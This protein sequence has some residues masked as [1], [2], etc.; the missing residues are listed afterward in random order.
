[1]SIVDNVTPAQQSRALW[2]STIA[3]TT[4]FAVW[5]IF[6]IIGLQIQ[7]DL[8]LSETEFGLLVG[9]PIL[10]GS[11]IR[12]ILG[13]WSDQ[14]GGRI[15][16]TIV[17]ITAAIATFLLT[18]VDTYFMYLVAAL[19]IGIA[20]GSFAVGIA[21][22][23]RW[24]P[25]EKQGTALGIFGLGNVGAAVT[26][27][28]APFV[29]VAFGWHAVAQI[30]GAALL[31]M[32]A[33]FWFVSED[34]PMLKARRVSGA[35]PD[36]FIKQLEPLKNIQVWRFSLYYFC[37]FGAFVALALWLPRYLVGAYGF[38]IKVAGMLAA[39]YSIFASLFRALG[40]WLSDRFGAR[41][42]M[43]WTFIV[44]A[45]CTF[46][47]S[48][49]PTDYVVHG[50]KGD[51]SF[52]LA[53]GPVGFIFLMSVLGLFMSFGKAAVYKHIPVYYPGNVGAVGGAVG[54][55]GGLGGFLLPLTFGM[56]NDLTGIWSSCFMLLFVLVM[57]ALTWMH[58]AIARMERRV[59]PELAQVSTYL[60][61]LSYPSSLVLTEWNP[62]DQ[63]FWEKT[64]KRI[65]TRNLWISIPA[66]LLAF[67]VWMVWSV[68]VINLPSIGF[69]YTTNELFWLAALPGLSGATL[70][71]F[72]SFM[73]PIFG[74]RRWTTIST[75]SLLLP[76]VWIGFAVQNPETPYLL[77]AVLALLCGFG[78]GNFASSMSNISFFYPQSQK[79]T[80]LG[81]NAGLGNLGVST[82][83]F[84]VPLVIATGVFGSW[85]GD[86]QVWIKADVTKNIWL[87][88]AGFIWVP[89]IL[90]TSIAAWFGMNDIASAKASFKE[91]SII[92][93][94]KH[95]YLMCW[96]YT[97]TFGSFIGYSA[98][99]PML[100]KILFPDVNPTQYAFLGPLVGAL[101]RPVGGWLA[102]KLGGAKVTLW[103]FVVMIVAVFG[104]L[105]FMPSAGNL[106]NFWGFLA[107]FMLLFITTGVGNGSTFRMIPV[108]F[109]TERLCEVKGQAA[110]VLAQARKDAAKEA[111]AVLGFSSAVAA[112]GAFFIPKSYGTAI[113]ITGSPDAAFY[114][115]IIFYITCIA[116]T[117]WN[118]ARKTASM[119]C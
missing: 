29:M 77:M 104:V 50:I 17:M 1:M 6:S 51:I 25:T 109:M 73:V 11:L 87:Q 94:R 28:I 7:K 62:E 34:E 14:Y 107:M 68:V 92:F 42:I 3:F 64:G 53:I 36:S 116:I 60:P 97:G 98:G 23:S 61:E 31:L 66:L 10:S 102:D 46:F 32:A 39:S 69:K 9:T 40:G 21:Y 88:N 27:F 63:N 48:Y 106:G 95:N 44:A 57:I 105:H 20:G 45:I 41:L 112:Y 55:V 83:Q 8:G 71:I 16:Y 22:T 52:S 100:I 49:P 85:G 82:V 37:V 118:Y 2:L 12:L 79:G 113:S 33:I 43:Y 78:G 13:I 81:L 56:L 75:A 103:N 80:A 110:E 76:S 15:V 47:L 18:T 5:T 70:R 99:L 24:F 117:W 38:D 84:V 108:I 26:K 101:I 111:A 74:G 67:A 54:M 93:K 89:F 119:P 35:K 59:V 114:C 72:Y 86:P 58:F 90:A 91:Q 96:L 65:A 4:C 115:F 19:G 30:W